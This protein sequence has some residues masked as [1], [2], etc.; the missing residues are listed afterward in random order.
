MGV[1]EL[2]LDRR[3]TEWRTVHLARLELCGWRD[4][5]IGPDWCLSHTERIRTS[6]IGQVTDPRKPLSMPFTPRGARIRWGHVG[7][8][9]WHRAVRCDSLWIGDVLRV[10]ATLHI[11]DTAG[12]ILSSEQ[13][14]EPV[15]LRSVLLDPLSA[16]PAAL[17]LLHTRP[18]QKDRLECKRGRKST[19]PVAAPVSWNDDALPAI[20]AWNDAI[21]ERV[22][23]LG[24]L[25]R[26]LCRM[27][28]AYAA[29]A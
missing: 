1:D 8:I 12:R 16:P 24:Q 19:R 29:I 21:G 15:A 4:W 9:E 3:G 25:N 11:R 5:A 27:I 10:H 2:E 18:A 28:A 20:A 13:A 7:A 17:S 6:F 23:E 14:A 26:S 22:F